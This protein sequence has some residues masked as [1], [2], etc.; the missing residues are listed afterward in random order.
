MDEKKTRAEARQEIANAD[1]KR[2][3][4]EKEAVCDN[5]VRQLALYMPTLSILTVP[6]S[7]DNSAEVRMTHRPESVREFDVLLN[8]LRAARSAFLNGGT[9]KAGRG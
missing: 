6:L 1:E 5:L 2:R 3:L 9:R 8:A 4:A 7:A